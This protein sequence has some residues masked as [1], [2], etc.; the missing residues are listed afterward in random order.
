MET[1]YL[2]TTIIGRYGADHLKETVL[3]GEKITSGA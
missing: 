2:L 3:E 1:N